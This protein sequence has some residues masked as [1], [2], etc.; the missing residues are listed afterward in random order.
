MSQKFITTGNKIELSL[1]KHGKVSVRETQPAYLSRFVQWTEP[2][3]AQIALP[4]CNGQ[5]VEMGSGDEY[6]LTFYTLKGLYRCEAVVIGQQGI[7]QTVIMKLVSEVEKYERRKFYRMDCILPMTYAVLTREQ[8]KRCKELA[9]ND[10]KE[11]KRFLR[12]QLASEAEFSYATILDISGGGMRFNSKAHQQAE[13]VLLLCPDFPEDIKRKLPLLPA[14]VIS[15]SP[16]KNR[17]DVYENRV[18]YIDISADERKIL[19]C[20][21]FQKEREK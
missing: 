21:I 3:M 11:Q 13:A 2:Y 5:Y 15:S 4:V 10:V 1:T 12:E 14:R 16:I 8:I 7:Q 9:G 20:Y 6:Q 17:E 19:I 18:E